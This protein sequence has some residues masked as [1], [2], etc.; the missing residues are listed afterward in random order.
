MRSLIVVLGFLACNAAHS[1]SITLKCSDSSGQPVA[2]L[3][4]DVSAGEMK[5]SFFNYR[6]TQHDHRYISA[7][8]IVPSDRIGGETWV[9]DRVTGQYIRAGVAI[10]G[11]TAVDLKLQSFTYA[12]VCNAPVL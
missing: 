5:W 10:L 11:P 9:L 2:D 3:T 4:V 1:A 7:Q 6:I 12:G 8:E